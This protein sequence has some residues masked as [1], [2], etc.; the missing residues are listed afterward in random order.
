METQTV[1]KLYNYGKGTILPHLE[2]TAA[3]HLPPT[4][5]L[6]QPW[7]SV[8]QLYGVQLYR[9]IRVLHRAGTFKGPSQREAFVQESEGP[10]LGCVVTSWGR[11]AFL[12]LLGAQPPRS[13]EEDKEPTLLFIGLWATAPKAD[14]LNGPPTSACGPAL[15]SS[16]P[17]GKGE[18]TLAGISS[19][20]PSEA[21]V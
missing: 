12:S 4:E 19:L 18:L 20:S 8:V 1:T 13:Q 16:V 14:C 6:G 5:S 9:E 17:W 10:V 21:I 7:H 11:G 15:L 3:A 2:H